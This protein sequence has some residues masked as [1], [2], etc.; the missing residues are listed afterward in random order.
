MAELQTLWQ[1]TGWRLK[2]ATHEPSWR[3]VLTGPSWRVLRH[4][5]RPDGR[6]DGRQDGPSWRLVCHRLYWLA[7]NAI[8]WRQWHENRART[9]HDT[10][11]PVPWPYFTQPDSAT[12]M[13][14]TTATGK[15]RWKK[16]QSTRFNMSIVRDLEESGRERQISSFFQSNS[17]NLPLHKTAA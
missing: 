2:P 5:A 8:S 1:L 16:I 13:A 3:P 7:G 6:R 9:V 12:S 10:N 14:S 11:S 15:W 4:T 17:N